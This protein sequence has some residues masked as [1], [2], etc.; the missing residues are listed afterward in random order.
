MRRLKL[1]TFAV[2]ICAL[3]VAVAAFLV[4]TPPGEDWFSFHAFLSITLATATQYVGASALFIMGLS[5]F[6]P[7]LK[8]AYATLCFGAS[9]L[10]IAFITLPLVSYGGAI[11]QVIRGPQLNAMAFVTALICIYAGTRSFARLFA[12]KNIT[13]A[14]WFAF[15]TPV[16]IAVVYGLLPHAP[17]AT[18]EL[19]FDLGNGF[20][21][22]S[23]WMTVLAL[24][25]IVQV[26]RLAGPLYTNALTWLILTFAAMLVAVV[27]HLIFV[28]P[29]G[30]EQWFLVGGVPFIPLFAA[31]A[32]FLR[33][34][35]AFNTITTSS[36]PAVTSSG[37]SQA[38]SV[39][40][41]SYIV[42]LVSEPRSVDPL[43]DKFRTVTAKIDP[44]Q[45][46]LSAQ[47]QK[48]LQQIYLDLETYLIEKEKLREFTRPGLR[49]QIA[50][51]L[52]LSE[53]AGTFWGS[54][55]KI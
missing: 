41:V 54:L 44:N 38:T 16:A 26:K 48:D 42:S 24:S 25:H 50:H 37:G 55:K 31:S 33:A 1:T 27:G 10:G 18:P 34:A 5:G 49:Q 29:F 20:N 22:F 21:I 43:L 32:C 2:V 11:E 7:K 15:I 23:M 36:V 47:D 19:Q 39:D 46:T 35:Y 6:T 45:P 4:P 30:D 14:W 17:T 12:I 3:L 40:I 13:T 8:R 9:V 52:R 28:L 51:D 53:A